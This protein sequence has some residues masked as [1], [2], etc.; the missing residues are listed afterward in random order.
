MNLG[1]EDAFVFTRLVCSGEMKRYERL[2]KGVDKGIVRKIELL[3][4]TVMGKTTLARIARFVLLQW[5]M[6]T[7]LFRGQFIKTVTGLDHPSRLNLPE[8]GP[9]RIIVFAQTGHGVDAQRNR[10]DDTTGDIRYRRA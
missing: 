4:R 7:P 5:L 3:S 2:R 1:L 8:T 9:K 6:P 10:T